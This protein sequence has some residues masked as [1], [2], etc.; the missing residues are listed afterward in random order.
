MHSCSRENI[1]EYIKAGLEFH[2][3]NGFDAADLPIDLIDLSKD[4]WQPYIEQ[5]KQAADEVGINIELCHLPFS[6]KVSAPSDYLPIF[7]AQMH[8]AI[9]AA[10]LLGVDYAVLHPNTSTLHMAKYDKIA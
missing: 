8:R 4:G 10:V 5:A 2:K 6:G 9:D 1:S 3:E 7:N